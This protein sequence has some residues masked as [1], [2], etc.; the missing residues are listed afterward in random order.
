[1]AIAMQPGND[2]YQEYRRSEAGIWSGKTVN[3][4]DSGTVTMLTGRGGW[5]E[6]DGT[7]V[8]IAT[9]NVDGVAL[10][11]VGR[12]DIIAY[13]EWVFTSFA[14]PAEYTELLALRHA[15]DGTAHALY[16]KTQY[17]CDGSCDLDLYYGRMASGGT[18][19]EETIQESKWGEPDDEFATNPTMVLD[20]RGEPVVAATF[21]KRVI[22]GSIKSAELRLY[23]RDNGQWCYETVATEVDGYQGSDG[24][25]MT[26]VSPFVTLDGS[27]RV[28]VAFQDKAQW[29]DSYNQANAV[30]GQIRY[31]VRSGKTWT[32][33][34][35]F[36]QDGEGTGTA[37]APLIGMLPTQVAISAD[38]ATVYAAGAEFEWDTDSI[39]NTSGKP[40]TF[41]AVV[42][43]AV[44]LLPE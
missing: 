9:A 32:L 15:P 18:W 12:L 28:H 21:F 41:K 8:V 5:Q 44:N 1:M 34:T 37:Q 6:A 26:G 14:L 10:G 31:A 43:K 16:T 7:M 22:T 38:G 25:E 35:L 23:G 33:A 11:I 36:E 40:M 13:S 24:T 17:P 20:S 19:L 4:V 2:G 29:H 39:Y 30:N 42:V 3:V 27:G